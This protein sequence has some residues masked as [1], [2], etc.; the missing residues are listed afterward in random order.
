MELVD[1]SRAHLLDYLTRQLANFFPDGADTR[2]TLDAHLDEA[3]ARLE[4]CIAAVKMWTPGRFH[5]LQSEQNTHFLY[6]LANTIWRA[7]GDLAVA[8]KLFY[9]NKALNGFHCFYD[10]ELPQR[11][12]VG[13]SVGIVLVR[14]KYPE[15]FVIY[16]GSTVG[17]N[18]NGAPD[19]GEGLIMYPGSAIIG[20]CT[21]G[22]N[23]VLAQG[24]SLVD[25]D[26]PGDCIVF[27]GS[28]AG[29]PVIKPSKRDY[30]S[31]FFRT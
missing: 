26:T 16:Q 10:T 5:Y 30:V 3:L 14:L 7:K 6:Y 11:F 19:L 31:E 29:R 1:S 9:L 24:A 8:T 15:H 22:P 2:P 25:A 20:R 27:P 13:H 12:Q 28:E 21:V 4:T 18:H 17:R 23:T